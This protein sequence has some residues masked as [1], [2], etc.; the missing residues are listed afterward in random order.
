MKC[1]ELV[2][3]AEIRI[4]SFHILLCRYFMIC[5]N[6]TMKETLNQEKID[7]KE[8][9]TLI[10][11]MQ[12]MKHYLS[13]Y[14]VNVISIIMDYYNSFLF[15]LRILRKLQKLLIVLL[16]GMLLFDKLFLVNNVL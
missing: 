12:R 14:A 9:S 8:L 4:P 10:R 2:L 7:T 11:D 1:I 5:W 15:N 13:S 3:T 16:I 6:E